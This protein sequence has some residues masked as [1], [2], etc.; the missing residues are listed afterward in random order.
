MIIASH[1][2]LKTNRDIN[3]FYGDSI[4][5]FFSSFLSPEILLKIYK[6]TNLPKYSRLW[7][8]RMGFL[9]QEELRFSGKVAKQS[10]AK[11]FKN[12]SLSVHTVNE[13]ETWPVNII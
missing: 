5:N 8:H 13:R 10:N 12:K 6:T 2:A 9:Q 1:K 4:L 3:I 11:N 7:L